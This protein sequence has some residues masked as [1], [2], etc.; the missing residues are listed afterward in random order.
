MMIT[1]VTVLIMNMDGQVIKYKILSTHILG[2]EFNCPVSITFT[3]SAM[4]AEL[5]IGL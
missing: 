3:F 4:K 1:P 5:A 2:E